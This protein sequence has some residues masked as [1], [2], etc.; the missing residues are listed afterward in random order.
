MS[1]GIITAG[2]VKAVLGKGDV[3]SFTWINSGLNPYPTMLFRLRQKKPPCGVF[4][5]N[6]EQG[7][8]HEPFL[9]FCCGFAIMKLR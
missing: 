1:I 6:K 4:R 2:L 7:T 5:R 9:L 3:F 8:H